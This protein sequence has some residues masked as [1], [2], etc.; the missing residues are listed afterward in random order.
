MVKINVDATLSRFYSSIAIVARYWRGQ[1][2]LACSIKVNTNLPPQAKAETLK[3]V[4]K[5]FANLV[6]DF[7]FIESDF[8]VIVQA[9]AKP[10]LEIG[11]S[12]ENLQYLL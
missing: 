7:I 5:L 8:K 6:F 3:W 11:N 2:V 10:E 4:I 12:M 9:L 1:L